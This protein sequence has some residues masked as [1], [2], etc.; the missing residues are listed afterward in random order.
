MGL[1]SNGTLL[2]LP[3]NTQDFCYM[4]TITAVQSLPLPFT[5]IAIKHMLAR[6]EL[7]R[8]EPLWDFTLIVC[9][10]PCLQTLKLFVIQQQLRQYKVCHCHSLP[11][12]P[13]ICWQ[14]WSLPKWRTY[15]TPSL[16]R[17][18]SSLLLYGNNYNS[19]EF[20][21][22]IHF[23]TSQTFAGKAGAYQN[24][25]T[26]GLHSKPCLQTLKLVV[27]LQQLRQ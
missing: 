18:H 17:N 10:Q 21:T 9:S 24:G 16:A 14:G 5:S 13:Y 23:H 22:A 11:Y 7:T 26:M 1:H 25:A 3:E 20:A 4:A 6:L 27:L 2:A 19:T 15:G 8:V 12:Q